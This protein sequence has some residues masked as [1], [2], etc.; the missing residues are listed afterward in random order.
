LTKDERLHEALTRAPVIPVLTIRDAGTAVQLAIALRDGGLPVLEITLRTP[1]AYDAM[2]RI[3]DEVADVVVG[4]GT[5]LVPEQ[6]SGAMACGAAFLVSPGSTP[7]LLQA[8]LDAPV[9]ML[10]AAATASEA[11]G[12]MERGFRHMKFF[13]AEPAGGVPY[14][15]ALAAPLPEA[16]FCP[17]GGLTEANAGQYLALSN[18]ICVGGAWV[19][20]QDMV[21][22]G[23]WAGI[24]A[25]ARRAAGLRPA[26]PEAA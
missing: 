10:P 14:L 22:A 7:A 18:V 3:K 5:V 26:R 11:M 4:A 9:P 19:A 16:V 6:I 13:P 1:S 20:P 8:A 24:T 21:D 12:L 25:L 2:R 23:N 15:K 17:T